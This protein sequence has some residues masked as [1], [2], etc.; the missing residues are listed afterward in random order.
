MAGKREEGGGGGLILTG[1][2]QSERQW[3]RD[4]WDLHLPS[5]IFPLDLTHRFF[6]LPLL[7]AT[8]PLKGERLWL[9]S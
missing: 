5:N 6:S 9:K 2:P 7:S 4:V 1:Y 8:A 3:C